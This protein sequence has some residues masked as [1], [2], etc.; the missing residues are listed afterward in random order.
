MTYDE[1]EEAKRRL[2][3]EREVEVVNVRLKDKKLQEE[4]LEKI[5]KKQKN[6]AIKHSQE[7]Q[8]AKAKTDLDVASNEIRNYLHLTIEDILAKGLAEICLTQPEDPVDALAEYLFAN[9]LK[10]NAPNPQQ[11]HSFK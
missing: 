1:E 7:Q 6:Q 11:H 8:R 9:A 3:Y 4:N 2:D 10:V 5:L